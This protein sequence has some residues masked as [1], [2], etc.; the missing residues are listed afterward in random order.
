MRQTKHSIRVALSADQQKVLDR[1]TASDDR[2]LVVIINGAYDEV[3]AQFFHVADA[4][5]IVEAF[6]K[7]GRL[8]K[9]VAQSKTLR[10]TYTLVS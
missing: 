7:R 4:G 6:V 8:R 5:T 1:F 2:R 9:D 3:L 10:A